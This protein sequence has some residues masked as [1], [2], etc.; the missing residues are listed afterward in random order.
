[1]DAASSSVTTT[2]WLQGAI[3]IVCLLIFEVLRKQKEVYAPKLRSRKDRYPPAP[4]MCLFGW[5][6]STVV[7]SDEDTLAYVGL[8]WMPLCSFISSKKRRVAGFLKLCFRTF[9]GCGAFAIVTLV[10]IYSTVEHGV[11]TIKDMTMRN[12]K[13]GGERLWASFVAFYLFN[14]VFLVLLYKGYEYFVDLRQ[15]FLK[16]GDPEFNPQISYSVLVEN[17]PAGYRSSEKLKELFSKLFPGEVKC[18]RILMN[19]SPLIKVATERLGYV[20]TLE[21]AE[22]SFEATDKEKVSEIKVKTTS[23]LCA[24]E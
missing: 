18:A 3:G 11:H 19:V 10:P 5:I 22:A 2:L 20:A 23:P 21:N 1:M 17:I 7:V 15:Q 14:T 24:A 12:I 6:K 9:L 13:Q 4:D 8:A 16:D